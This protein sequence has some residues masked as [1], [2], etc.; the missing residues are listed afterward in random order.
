MTRSRRWATK[1]VAAISAAFLLASCSGGTSNNSSDGASGTGGDITIA[2]VT[3][4]WIFPISAP[5][6]TQGENG[7]MI[8]MLYR[9]MF[10]YD[11]SAPA[12]KFNISEAS[13]AEIPTVS[14]DGKTF[15]IKMKDAT[16]NDGKEITTRDVEFWWNLLTNNKESWSGYREGGF[17]DNV[18][19]MKFVDDKTIELTTKEVFNPGWYIDN[20]LS[21]MRPLPAH[22][23][24]KTEAG[25]V[26]DGDRDPATAKEIFAYLTKAS[27][28]L[29]SYA[30]NDLWKTVSG[31]YTLDK[32]V[33]S[34][35]VRF[36]PVKNWSGGE[37]K[38]S[39]IVFRPFTSDDAQFNVL[40]SGGIDF[41]Y[42]PAG[43]ISQKEAIEKLGYTVEPWYG[44]SISYVPFNFANP[45][46]GPIFKQKY[47]RQAMQML[48]DQESISKVIWAG[49]AAP[50]CGPVP[51]APGEGGSSEGCA[52]KFDP[53]AAKKLL[54]DNGWKVNPGGVSVCENA[55]SGAGQCGEGVPAGAELS[56]KFISQS[57]FPATTKMTTEMNSRFSEAGIKLEIQEVPDSV[58]V[59]QKCVE[60]EACDWDLSWFGSQSS[61]YYPVYASGERLYATDAPVNLGQYSNTEA[62][63]LIDATKTS[64]DTSAMIA[65]N[66][67]LAE[68]LPVLWMPNP[69]NRIAAFKSNI[70]GISPLSPM[71]NIYPHLWERK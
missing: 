43:S 4:T 28:D 29:Q 22:A 30:T 53:E 9:S 13:L 18:E 44:W 58:A 19:S 62:D 47:V 42:I 20:Q 5:G 71:I 61:W 14:E 54:A 31:A 12:D 34:G 8:S 24:S 50:T 1:A 66:D 21:S 2:Q 37:V 55:G 70:E 41:G 17:P 51:Q 57:G 39:G 23:W 7:M 46:T 60:G 38:N 65:Y 63:K 56:F 49:M 27:E 52:Y 15:T 48:I 32:F 26:A 64:L 68:D 16:W 25:E 59:S 11:L 40:R 69:V 67:Y 33:P 3:P 6:K 45:K 10:E 35:E 36:E